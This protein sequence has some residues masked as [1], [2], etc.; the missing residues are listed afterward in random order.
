MATCSSL[1]AELEG[2]TELERRLRHD[3]LQSLKFAAVSADEKWLT[4]FVIRIVLS[5]ALRQNP[6]PTGHSD[7][8]MAAVSPKLTTHCQSRQHFFPPPLRCPSPHTR[9]R[10]MQATAAGLRTAAR[11]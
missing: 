5:D 1:S 3:S 6:G 9:L 8:S 4:I 2:A 11:P 7:E 10:A